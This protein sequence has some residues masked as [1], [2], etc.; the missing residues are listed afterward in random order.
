MGMYLFV[1]AR[2]TQKILY[3]VEKGEYQLNVFANLA[4]AA[5]KIY[6]ISR[7]GEIGDIYQLNIPA[8]F[9]DLLSSLQ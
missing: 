8:N 2:E 3:F 7:F 6:S 9:Q 1:I 5:S 4:T